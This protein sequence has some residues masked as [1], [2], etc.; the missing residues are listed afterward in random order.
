MIDKPM[1]LSLEAQRSGEPGTAR[2]DDQKYTIAIATSPGTFVPL[3]GNKQLEQ[4]NEKYW[5]VN[6]PL[7]M[8]YSL[9]KDSDEKQKSTNSTK[10]SKNLQ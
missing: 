5:R 4:V 6:K 8:F 3:N 9:Q 7:E 2:A 10:D 1:R